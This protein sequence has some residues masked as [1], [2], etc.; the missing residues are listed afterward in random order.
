MC[1]RKESP[2]KQGGGGSQG[3]QGGW[4]LA[5][6]RLPGVGG[7]RGVCPSSSLSFQAHP[8]LTAEHDGQEAGGL[9][10][11]PGHGLSG[12]GGSGEVHILASR[13]AGSYCPTLLK[14]THL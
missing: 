7:S 14:L 4:T 1:Q 8:Q 9:C 2:L 5:E 6:A 12:W 3:G 13:R 10:L 11:S